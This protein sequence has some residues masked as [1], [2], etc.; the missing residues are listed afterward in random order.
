MSVRIWRRQM[1]THIDVYISSGH[2]SSEILWFLSTNTL[3]T[4]GYT[5]AHI[6]QSDQIR[7]QQNILYFFSSHGA[8]NEAV[9][10]S[11]LCLFGDENTYCCFEGMEMTR[12]RGGREKASETTS[13]VVFI[14]TMYSSVFIWNWENGNKFENWKIIWTNY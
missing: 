6:L 3:I 12:K 10:E 5:C 1:N 11:I 13:R 8:K 14:Q 9:H 7:A 4:S 2:F